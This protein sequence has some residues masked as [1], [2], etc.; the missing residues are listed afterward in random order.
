MSFIENKKARMRFAVKET[1]EAGI[2]LI[3]AEVKTLR[4]KHGSLDG[5]HIVIR[6]GEAYITG[7]TIPPYQASNTATSYDPERN[8]RL[9]LQKKEIAL[10][11]EA[12]S[13][14]GLT[15]VPLSVYNKGRYIKM[16]VA[17][18]QGKDK[19]DRR[20]DIKRLEAERE[21]DRVMKTRKLA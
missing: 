5:A 12:E 15:V 13:R 7:M 21:A 2:E 17:I 8:R 6:G 19:A 16:Q 10:L 14:K 20:E 4:A 1:F 11:S 9:L 3:G 18:V